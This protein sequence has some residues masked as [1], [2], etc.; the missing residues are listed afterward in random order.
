MHSFIHIQNH[1]PHNQ[2]KKRLHS[3]KCKRFLCTYWFFSYNLL[4]WGVQ[5]F[6][7]VTVPTVSPTMPSISPDTPSVW[8]IIFACTVYSLP[9]QS[10]LNTL[11]TKVSIGC[12]CMLA[13]SKQ[14]LHQL[15]R[16]QRHARLEENTHYFGRKYPCI[17][18]YTY[19][20]FLKHEQIKVHHCTQY[21]LTATK[22]VTEP[23]RCRNN[24]DRKIVK[25]VVCPS[26]CWTQFGA[27]S[28]HKLGLHTTTLH[29]NTSKALRNV[30]QGFC[31]KQIQ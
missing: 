8:L 6:T 27:P 25:K 13:H 14:T 10:S 16:R 9:A 24:V 5:A 1:Q 26:R 12:H 28:I 17:S 7:F 3:W 22:R 4:V 2:Q 18:I 23:M 30:S 20:Y 31:Y 15:R 29:K 19:R 11:L 21:N